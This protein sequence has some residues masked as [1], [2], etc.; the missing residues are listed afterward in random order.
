MALPATFESAGVL[1]ASA[2]R[3]PHSF[4][5]VGGRTELVGGDMR[6]H[7]RLPGRISGVPRGSLQLSCCSHGMT[8]RGAGLRHP[9]LP[10][11]PGPDLFDR[12]AGPRICGL[13]RLEEVQNVFCARRCPQSQEVMV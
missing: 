4:D 11:G 9:D 7:C 3:R 2:G 13:H 12:M 10:A 8:T 5:R 6:H 1:F